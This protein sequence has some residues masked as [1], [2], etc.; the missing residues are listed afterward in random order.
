MLLSCS[1]ELNHIFLSFSPFSLLLSLPPFYLSLPCTSSILFSDYASSFASWKLF[2]ILYTF[3]NLLIFSLV[4]PLLRPHFVVPFLFHQLILISISVNFP[5][6]TGEYIYW[7][8]WQKRTIERVHKADGSGREIII[9]SLPELMGLK[10]ITM[11]KQLG[12][13]S[14]FSDNDS[15]FRGLT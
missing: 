6:F 1:F 12:K 5:S 14:I 10:A 7:T 13:I 9:E 15:T 2:I 8:D 3:P 11:E 4:Y